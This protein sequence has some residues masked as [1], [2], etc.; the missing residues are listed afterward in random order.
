MTQAYNLS[1]LANN[2]NSSGQLDATDGLVNAVPATNGG[3][4][5][6]GYAVGDLLYA[7]TTTVLNRLADV[8]VGNALISGGVGVAPAYGKIALTTHVSGTLPVSN[9]GTGAAT[10]AANNV[11]LGNGT[12]ALQAVAPSTNGN[13]LTSNGTTWISAPASTAVSSVNGVTGAVVTTTLG[14]IGSVVIAANT[15]TSY[16]LPG[17]TIAGSSL[18]YTSTF[19][20]AS[21]PTGVVSNGTVGG[22]DYTYNTINSSTIRVTTSNVGYQSPLGMTALSGTWRALAFIGARSVSWDGTNNT[23]YSPMGLWV[24]VS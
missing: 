6:A 18:V 23:S 14:N 12:S 22:S 16:Y 19:V 13:V 3:T 15:S 20:S 11:L 9:G 24:R 8:A 5:Q 17:S 2:L 21:G 7:S 4:G 10:L 1:Q